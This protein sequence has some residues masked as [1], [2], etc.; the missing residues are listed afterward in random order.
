MHVCEMFN[1][2]SDLKGLRAFTDPEHISEA[3]TS[4]FDLESLM[5]LHLDATRVEQSA[6]LN[7]DKPANLLHVL[8][9]QIACSRLSGLILGHFKILN[10]EQIHVLDAI[11]L[12]LLCGCY[13]VSNYAVPPLAA[14]SFTKEMEQLIKA[15]IGCKIRI[16]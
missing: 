14:L 1:T 10:E 16:T 15:V 13:L 3:L 12:A 9:G 5:S 2:Y 6:H 8:S 11:C 4:H 7:Q